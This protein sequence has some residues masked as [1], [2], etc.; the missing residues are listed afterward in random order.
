MPCST[1]WVVEVLSDGN[2][3]LEERDGNLKKQG[4]VTLSPIEIEAMSEKPMGYIA[5]GQYQELSFV[6]YKMLEVCK[7]HFLRSIVLGK[8][9]FGTCLWLP[10]QGVFQ[11]IQ[12]MPDFS[13]PSTTTV[14]DMPDLSIING[15]KSVE[16]E[17]DL[18]KKAIIGV[19]LFGEWKMG[20]FVI[21]KEFEQLGDVT[22]LSRTIWDGIDTVIVPSTIRSFTK[23]AF[24]NAGIRKL[25]CCASIQDIPIS[26]MTSAKVQE[27]EFTKPVHVISDYAFSDCEELVSFKTPEPISYIGRY[28]FA[29]TVRLEE[30]NI[31]DATVTVATSFK[32]SSYVI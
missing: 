24:A 19:R 8:S 17:F 14:I 1:L 11:I 16:V 15:I 20:Y 23:C 10:E 3:R 32:G 4:E 13:R 30:I 12:R 18:S 25:V 21:P 7:Q 26:C 22:P 5:K 9:A 27:I 29:R 2:I 6:F 28:G 31:D